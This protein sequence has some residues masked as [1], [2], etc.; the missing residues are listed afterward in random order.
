M[1]GGEKDP[2]FDKKGAVGKQLITSSKFAAK[3][4]RRELNQRLTYIPIAYP[5]A[6]ED[7]GSVE[8][9]QRKDDKK[10]ILFAGR[11]TPDKGVYTLLASLHMASMRKLDY[12]LTV[13]TAGSHT[14]DGRL[15]HALIK[16]HPYVRVVQACRTRREMAELMAAHDMVVIPS[17]GIFWKEAFGVLSVEAQHAGCRVVASNS[18]GLP[19]TNCGG[20]MLVEPDNPQSLARGITK[21]SRLGPLSEAERLYARTKFTLSE[22]VDSLLHIVTATEK[23]RIPHLLHKQGGFVWEQLDFTF[24]NMRQ[25]GLQIAGEKELAKYKTRSARNRLA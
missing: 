17:T 9:P 23:E 21:A 10:R 20:L 1:S 25:L 4:W 2:L 15:I 6:E 12:E 22:S 11:L 8:R 13:T 19:E 3:L 18:G 14:E 5:F 24:S 7:F 16:A